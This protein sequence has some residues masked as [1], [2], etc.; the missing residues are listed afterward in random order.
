MLKPKIISEILKQALS[1]SINTA[2]LFSQEGSLLSYATNKYNNVGSPVFNSLNDPSE[3]SKVIAAISSNVWSVYKNSCS[4]WFVNQQNQAQAQD[5]SLNMIFLD[6]EEGKVI[7]SQ[8]GKLLIALVGNNDTE[9]GLLKI[10]MT[11]LVN[12]FNNSLQ[13]F[14]SDN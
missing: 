12:Y 11:T 10:K 8:A 4:F 2:I 13:Y 5:D 9:I 1:S 3:P 7:I 6:C 14:G